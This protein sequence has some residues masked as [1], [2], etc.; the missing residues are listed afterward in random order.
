MMQ[1]F[2]QVL[3]TFL[4]T[5]PLF[6][7][8]PINPSPTPIETP[9]ISQPT[10]ELSDKGYNLLQAKL[11]DPL[12]K[13]NNHGVAP[14]MFSRCG[15]GFSNVLDESPSAN[16]PYFTGTIRYYVGCDEGLEVG[17]F[18]LNSTEDKLEVQ[19]KTTKQFISPEKW[20]SD[21]ARTANG[22]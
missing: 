3:V 11:I 19:D 14:Q 6:T 21:Y 8:A 10:T 9:T 15:S 4:I 20:L 2:F 16:N 5:V 7:S 13:I 12:T 22:F 1:N 17:K 18:R